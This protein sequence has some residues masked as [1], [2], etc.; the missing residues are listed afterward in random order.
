VTQPKPYHAAC[1]LVVQFSKG[2][3]CF[4]VYRLY[5]ASQSLPILLLSSFFV[6]KQRPLYLTTFAKALQQLFF[7]LPPGRVLNL[8]TGQAL[9]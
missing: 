3:V 2:H 9:S 4:T 5:Q 8:L 6:S 7:K 1:F